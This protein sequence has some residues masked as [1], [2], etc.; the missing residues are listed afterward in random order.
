MKNHSNTHPDNPKE[1]LAKLLRILAIPSKMKDK[2]EYEKFAA[3][4]K[5][6]IDHGY[7]PPDL[8]NNFLKK[9]K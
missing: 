3:R 6:L 5:K 4:A 8:D 2:R 9:E 1:E 7:G